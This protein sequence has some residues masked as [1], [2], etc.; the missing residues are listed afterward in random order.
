[1]VEEICK[2]FIE[3]TNH[4]VIIAV[5]NNS[6]GKTIVE[7]LRLHGKDGADYTQYLYFEKSKQHADGTVSEYGLNTNSR[8]KDLMASS[9]M[10]FSYEGPEYFHSE[11]LITQLHGITRSNSGTLYHT[12]YSEINNSVRS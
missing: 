5:E 1:M 3:A 2:L 8:T 6:I 12:S 9:F 10:D 4:R 7:H 11:E